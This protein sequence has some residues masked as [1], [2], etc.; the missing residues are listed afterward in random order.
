M[1]ARPRMRPDTG[2]KAWNVVVVMSDTLR[3]AYMS[4]YGND[5]ITS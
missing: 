4:P 1:S 2:D 3:T 5:W